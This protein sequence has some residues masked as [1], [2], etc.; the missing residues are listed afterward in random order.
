MLCCFSALRWAAGLLILATLSTFASA[1]ELIQPIT[2][3]SSAEQKI[4]AA[5]DSKT[6]LE[7]IETPLIDI[8]EF[9]EEL[10]GIQIEIDSRVI[11]SVGIGNDT[12]ITRNLSGIS[13]RSALRILLSDLELAYIVEDDVLLITTR[14]ESE[15]N[16]GVLVYDVSSMLRGG[17]TAN[18]LARVLAQTLAKEQPYVPNLGAYGGDDAGDAKIP[19]ERS[20]SI[21]AYRHL[22]IVRDT[23]TGHREVAEVLTAIRDGLAAKPAGPLKLPEG[24]AAPTA[25]Q[26]E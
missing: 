4:H 5:L 12:P 22:L 16:S 23:T 21:S 15:K 6:K 8:V 3:T 14:Q 24:D 1:G 20:R 26:T 7:F 19:I 11:D 2:K 13:F 25:D 17:E 10:H 9:L 18:E